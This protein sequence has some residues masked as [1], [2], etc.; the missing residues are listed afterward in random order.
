MEVFKNLV[1]VPMTE[2][3]LE[4]IKKTLDTCESFFHESSAP[5]ATPLLTVMVPTRDRIAHLLR[6]VENVRRC[7]EALG[8]GGEVLLVI[9]DNASPK[10][11]WEKLEEAAE[12]YPYG[13]RILRQKRNIGFE[14]NLLTL[15]AACETHY[16]MTLGDDDYFDEVLLGR[17][18]GYLRQGGFSAVFPN[19][20]SVDTEGFPLRT[21]TRDP[22]ASDAV[23]APGD[24]LSFVWCAHQVS[25]LT[26]EVDGILESYLSN[27]PES[28]Y[29]QVYFMGVAVQ[30]GR[31]VHITEHPINVTQRPSA[32]TDWGRGL[33]NL[34][35]DLLAA[36]DA[37]PV[38][39]DETKRVFMRDFFRAHSG[40]IC[41]CAG[42]LSPCQ[43]QKR[44]ASYSLSRKTKNMVIRAF[45][46][47]YVKIP[48]RVVRKAGHLVKRA[49]GRNK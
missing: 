33:D 9:S 15:L 5:C 41:K 37:V 29:P 1:G 24:G 48:I 6:N 16:A 18:L 46:L 22:V 34:L 28:V 2:R 3:T 20:R 30:Q 7:I 14:M 36:A 47:S 25:G 45:W 17:V 27:C 21:P 44:V 43:V 13:I 12:A 11:Q 49:L 26:F 8:A 42:W 4:S 40:R 19:C 23:L 38:E 35:G 31:S 39:D 10:D 32:V